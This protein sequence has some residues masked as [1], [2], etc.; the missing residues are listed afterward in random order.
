MNKKAKDNE[1][2]VYADL[3]DARVAIVNALTRCSDSCTVS[4]LLDVFK[5]IVTAEDV[6]M[7]KNEKEGN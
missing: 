4:A 7:S 1:V 2:G 5:A 6:H 3:V